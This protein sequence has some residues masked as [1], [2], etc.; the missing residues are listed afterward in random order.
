MSQSWRGIDRAR[1]T[2][3]HRIH[4]LMV[5]AVASTV[6]P[7]VGEGTMDL[8]TQRALLNTQEQVAARLLHRDIGDGSALIET[9]ALLGAAMYRILDSK[10]FWRDLDEAVPGAVEQ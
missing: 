2:E 7:F 1:P 9:A 4:R 10:E 5:A 6:A 3:P 8:D